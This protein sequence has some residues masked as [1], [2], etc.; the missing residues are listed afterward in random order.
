[1]AGGPGPVVSPETTCRT[2]AD[3]RAGWRL[4]VDAIHE[5][6]DDGCRLRELGLYEGTLVT[7]VSH[8]DPIIL[9]IFSNRFAVCA[10]CARHVEVSVVETG[11]GAVT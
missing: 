3:G 7:V 10:R 6:D 1:M 2:L 5:N 9:S 4:R 8:G 11:R